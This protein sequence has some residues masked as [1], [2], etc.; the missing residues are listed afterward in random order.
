[1]RV[2]VSQ[3]FLIGL[4]LTSLA[5]TAVTSIAVF[6]VFQQEL[7]RRQIDFLSQYVQERTDNVDHHFSSLM[8]LQK[9]A[10]DT[11]AARVQSITQPE[12]DAL[13]DRETVTMPDG[14]RR[15]RDRAFEGY[16]DGEGG[17][18]Y[19]VGAFIGKAGTLSPS[20]RKVLAAAFPIVARFGQAAHGDYDNFYFFSP[21]T[22]LVMFGPDRADHLK[23]YRHEAP[24]DLD[25]SQE[26]MSK[27]ITPAAVRAEDMKTLIQP[28]P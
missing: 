17:R 22:R 14:T 27:F 15:S 6:G 12:A 13:L 16:I 2:S 10:I 25:I 9:S 4:G 1:M 18:V 26:E 24:A 8:T 28:A 11:L 21:G 23:F 3:R 20:D 5:F 7:E 19:G